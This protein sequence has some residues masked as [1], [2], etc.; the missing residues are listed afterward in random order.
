MIEDKPNLYIFSGLPGVGKTT[1]ARLLSKNTKSVYLRIDTIEQGIRDLCSFKVEGEGYRLTYR[2]ARDNLLL[3]NNVI[4]DS[5]N[6][7]ELTRD[8]W[9]QVA[10]E[11]GANFINIEVLC[12]DKREHKHRVESRKSDIPN[13]HL[14]TW[15]KVQSREFQQWKK[16][17]IAIDTAEK[18]IEQS[19]SE[20]L[21]KIN[22]QVN[23]A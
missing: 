1:L 13:L 23:E 4:S 11:S 7:I 14:P 15:K 5:T 16:D 22:K 10:I 19:L 20:L 3:G 8:E 6:P 9:E 2:I 17:C 12:S 18:T 21:E